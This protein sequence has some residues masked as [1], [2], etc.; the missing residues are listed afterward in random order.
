MESITDLIQVVQ[1][2]VIT[3][4]LELIKKQIESAV[5]Y[6]LS[7]DCNESTYPEITQLKAE[8]NKQ[9][10]ELDDKR[11]EAKKAVLAP[12]NEFEAVFNKYVRDVFK[13]AERQISERISSVE[14]SLKAAKQ[15]EVEEYFGEYAKSIGID[16]VPFERLQLNITMSASLKSL[17][18]QV[19]EFLDNAIQDLKLIATQKYVTETLVE[20]RKTLNASQSILTVQERHRAL[21]ELEAKKAESEA[22]ATQQAEVIKKVDEAIQEFSAPKTEEAESEE[23]EP[24]YET[25]FTVRGTMVQLKKLKA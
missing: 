15:K 22:E 20:Y 23:N 3:E 6:V 13:P 2:P 17:K 18:K 14:N 21:E 25:T 19:K 1:L 10:Q 5:E 4:Q 11:K 12:Y 16:F 7:L 8:L 9:Y 24:I